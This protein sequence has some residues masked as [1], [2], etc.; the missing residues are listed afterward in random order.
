MTI[1]NI[2]NIAFAKNESCSN[3]QSYY[4]WSK[5]NTKHIDYWAKIFS[6]TKTMFIGTFREKF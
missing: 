1:R 3:M 2:T 4:F 6:C 5:M